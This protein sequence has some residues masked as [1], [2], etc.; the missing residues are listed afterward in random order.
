LEASKGCKTELGSWK[1]KGIKLM[2]K[3]EMVYKQ[4]GFGNEANSPSL[5]PLGSSETNHS[6]QY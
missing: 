3:K 2:S 5:L 1:I 6:V 4:K